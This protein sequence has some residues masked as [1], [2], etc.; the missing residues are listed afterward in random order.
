M[1]THETFSGVL[2]PV[3]TP[4]SESL[5]PDNALFAQHC[6]WLLDQGADGLAVFGTTSE[7]NSLAI[8]ER[9]DMRLVT[10]D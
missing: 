5:Q 7:A 1:Q 2:V 8:G 6:Q 4:F 3:A 9:I 10:M